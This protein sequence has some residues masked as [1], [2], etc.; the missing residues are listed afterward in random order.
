MKPQDYSYPQRCGKTCLNCAVVISET[1]TYSKCILGIER[2]GLYSKVVLILEC[3]H[4]LNFKLH[5]FYFQSLDL[6]P[7]TPGRVP[8]TTQIVSHIIRVIIVISDAIMHHLHMY[9]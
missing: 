3:L 5:F 7:C 1:I 8:S 4:F 9:A 2:S 6:K